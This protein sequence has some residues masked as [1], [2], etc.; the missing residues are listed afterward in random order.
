MERTVSAALAD[1]LLTGR[2]TADGGQSLLAVVTVAVFWPVV[3]WWMAVGWLGLFL[4]STSARAAHRRSVA[5]RFQ[6]RTDALLPFLRRDVWLST[7]L[8]TGWAILL[9]G[10]TPKD[11]A[12]LLV[13]YSGLVSAG[14]STLMSDR[15]AFLG[16]MAL[17]EVPLAAVILLSGQSWD[18]LSQVG[19]IVLFGG[20]MLVVHKRGHERLAE[21]IRTSERLRSSEE[22]TARRRDFLNSLVTSAPTAVVV[23]DDDGRIVTTNPAMERVTGFA[24]AEVMGRGLSSLLEDSAEQDGFEE[25]FDAVR[26]GDRRVEEVPLRHRDGHRVWMRVSGTRAGGAAQGNLIFVGEDVSQQVAAQDAKEHARLEAERVARAKSAFLASMSHEIRTPLNGILGMVELLLDS[27]LDN[28]QREAA[29]TVRSSGRGLLQILNDVLDVSKI[30]A[31]QI[32]LEDIDFSL[33]DV[34]K[35]SSRVLAVQAD[36]KG[37]ELAV[38]LGPDVPRRVRGDPVRIRQVLTNL[39]SNAVKFTEEGEVVVSLRRVGQTPDGTALRFTVRDTGIGIAPEKHS[40][41]FQEFEQADS[42]TTRTYGGTGLGLTI[43]RRLVELMGG[44]FGLQS[45]PGEGSEFHFT[46]TL[47]HP[48]VPG[49]TG[50][51]LMDRKL[52]LG[53]RRFLVV[54][55]NE[56]ARRIVREGLLRSGAMEVVE[57]PDV[58]DGLEVLARAREA[59]EAFDAVV[60]DHMMPGRDGMDF[61]RTVRDDPRYGSPPLLMLTSGGVSS[62]TTAK[63]VG[64]AGYLSKPVARPDL[65]QALAEILLTEDPVPQERSL[66]TTA[67][68]VASRHH[69][70]ILLAE[71]NPV[72][73]RVATALLS[74]RGYDVTPVTDGAQAVQAVTDHEPFDLVLM[75]IQMP[76]M[77][78]LD[79]TRAILE[80]HPDLPVVALTAHAFAEQRQRTRDVGM[81]DFLAKPFQPEDLYEVVDRWTRPR[82]RDGVPEQEGSDEDPASDPHVERAVDLEAF[83]ELMRSA[84]IEEV[85]DSTVAIYMDEGPRLM[86][87]ITDAVESGDLQRAS[88][89]AHNLKSSSANLRARRL[90]AVLQELEDAA[91]AHGPEVG[92]LHEEARTEFEATMQELRDHQGNG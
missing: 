39:L 22:E 43:C 85:V 67:S 76:T 17:L 62:R 46:I 23:T 55:D 19:L 37:L 77:D 57:A 66:V 44:E 50:T 78:G 40:T 29:E 12:L 84:G 89:T 88:E 24:P 80:S 60:L 79:A 4:V 70:R 74:R 30:E 5:V 7:L 36:T 65:L 42:S 91:A 8:W 34:V 75:D 82:S 1:R 92:R 61:A 86:Q 38:D 68:L 81:V 72:N 48:R 16:F 52:E 6:D 9:I 14:A 2:T 73:M 54:D 45:E 59:E 28:S 53:S 21:Q 35:E 58:D 10:S 15:P 90:A 25:F 71:D 11:L 47:P 87:R 33:T 20:F 31:G 64:I 49:E 56:T 3:P 32:D 13:I 18:H 69:V 63:E 26:R 27:E 51:A 41:V 83:R